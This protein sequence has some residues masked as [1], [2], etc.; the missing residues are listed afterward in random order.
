MIRQPPN[1]EL[2]LPKPSE[3]RSFP[4]WGSET[5]VKAGRRF[6]V[7]TNPR[8]YDREPVAPYGLDSSVGQTSEM[9]RTW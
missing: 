2:K 1:K 5:T 8:S 4:P 6:A 3:L 7:L 9:R